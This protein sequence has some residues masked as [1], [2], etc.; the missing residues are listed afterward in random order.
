[1]LFYLANSKKHLYEYLGGIRYFARN[2]R[3]I[4]SEI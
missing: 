1:M 4:K 2:Y 3:D